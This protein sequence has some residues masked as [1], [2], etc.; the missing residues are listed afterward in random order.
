MLVLVNLRTLV[1][2]TTPVISE[3]STSLHLEA[4]IPSFIDLRVHL[5]KLVSMNAYV[6]HV[7]FIIAS[8]GTQWIIQSPTTPLQ[9]YP[10]VPVF[11][12]I[13]NT[14]V[15]HVFYKQRSINKLQ[16]HVSIKNRLER[17]INLDLHALLCK[18]TYT[19]TRINLRGSKFHACVV[20]NIAAHCLEPSTRDTRIAWPLLDCE[21]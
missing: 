5:V 10:V 3:C 6:L 17:E 1:L 20:Y 16:P 2:L 4:Y 7:G 21:R 12:N 18:V 15:L 19:Y 14:V 9:H 11:F 13:F 8:S